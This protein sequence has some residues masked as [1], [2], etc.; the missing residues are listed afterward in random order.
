MKVFHFQ[1]QTLAAKPCKR[2]SVRLRQKLFLRTDFCDHHATDAPK[3][4]SEEDTYRTDNISDWDKKFMEVPMKLLF[5]LILAANFLD[6]KPL[7]DLGCKVVANQIKGKDFEELKK[8]FA[9][10]K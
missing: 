9:I 5:D 6:I 10:P 2:S 1:L 7:L 4:V 3:T 8:T